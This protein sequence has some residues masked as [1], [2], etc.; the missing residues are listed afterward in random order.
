MKRTFAASFAIVLLLYSV[1]AGQATI[2]VGGLTAPVTVGRDGR[3]IPYIEAKTDADVYF[4][5]GYVM[6]SDR[7][8]Q[9]DMMRRVARGETAELFGRMTL[10]ED[11]RW[12]RFNFAKVADETLKFLP[13]DLHA[14]LDSYAAGVNAYIAT[15]TPETMPV[16]FRML[17]YK[18][19]DWRPSD[20]IVVGKILS[21]ALSSTWRNDL[22][23]ASLQKMPADK[24]ADLTDQVTP[25]DVVLFGKDVPA[26]KGRRPTRL[27]GHFRVICS[28]KPTRRKTCVPVR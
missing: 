12:R 16:E 10:E 28:R 27:P 1:V 13:P 11:K 2:N 14:A 23:R 7:L 26:I 9:M 19:R 8:W 21:D 20:T 6:A 15:L 4:A 3:S 17:Q 25:Y 24:L 5:Q 22:L 18:P